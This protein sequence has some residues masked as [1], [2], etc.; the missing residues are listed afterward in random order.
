MKNTRTHTKPKSEET[1]LIN[2]TVSPRSITIS[3]SVPFAFIKE[4]MLGKRYELSIAFVGDTRMR[5]LNRT[6]RGK[7][8]STDVLSFP[9]SSDSGEIIFS[10]ARVTQKAKKFSLTPREYLAY[11]F[12]H[13]I[14][15]L[16]GLE[17]GRTMEKL[18]DS[19]CRT[20]NIQPPKR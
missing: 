7:D 1:L 17:H 15:H 9:L 6:Y 2:S 5:T 16:K 10:M 14:L 4:K 19:W 8:A 20:L 18:E 12:I 13:G 3:R 11:L